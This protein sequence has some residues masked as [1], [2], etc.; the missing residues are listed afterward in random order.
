MF[1]MAGEFFEFERDE[2]A[3]LTEM[4]VGVRSKKNVFSMCYKAL[5]AINAL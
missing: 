1:K 5:A 3:V 4:V 2:F